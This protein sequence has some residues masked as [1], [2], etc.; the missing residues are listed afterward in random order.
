MEQEFNPY[1]SGEVYQEYAD[2]SV[3]IAVTPVALGAILKTR[4]W[5]KL[6]GIV[7]L[8]ISVLTIIGA[9]V[10]MRGLEILG[11][12][13]VMISVIVMLYIFIGAAY[14]FMAVRLLKY[15]GAIKKL[16]LSQD[17]NDLARAMEM[18][19]KF[20]KLVGILTIIL[21]SLYAV[22]IGITIIMAS[23]QTF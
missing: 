22:L 20:W 18:Q 19:T 3:G 10:T 23:R 13:G 8:L 5:V 12:V 4:V 7:M 15:A 9:L 6:V 21:M 1:A 16:S 2:P 11:S 17:T 14:I